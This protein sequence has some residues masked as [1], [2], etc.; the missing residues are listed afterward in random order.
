MNFRRVIFISLF[1]IAAAASAFCTSLAVQ[2]VQ[3]NSGVDQVCE[4]SEYFEQSVIDFFFESG[5]IVSNSPIFISVN[6]KKDDEECH[7]SIMAASE[8]YLTYFT[9]IVIE[10]STEKSTNPEA[11][12]LENIKNVSWKT[13]SVSSGKQISGGSAVPDAITDDN[14][15]ESGITS[16]AGLVAAKISAGLK[17]SR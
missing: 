9:S 1:S 10:Y 11:P 12:L 14:N 7:K 13:Y 8:G 6:D 2:I 4:T 15:N 16:F 3:K 5:H 17:Q